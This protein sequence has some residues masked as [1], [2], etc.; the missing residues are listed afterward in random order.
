MLPHGV[1]AIIEYQ[2][3]S[4]MKILQE[5]RVII[6]KNGG[7]ESQTA[8]MFEK[9]GKIW[10]QEHDQLSENDVLDEAIEA[11][12]TD[13][14][15]EDGR[16]V[17]ETVPSGLSSVSDALQEKLKL[18]V[19]RADIIFDPKEASEVELSSEQS[20]DIDRVLEKL[21]DEPCL[22]SIYLNAR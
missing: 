22:Q 7:R 9:K 5:A 18:I 6:N 17:V 20:M 1:A 21:E 15:T 12:A 11:G 8:F 16:I 4:K 10:F 19:E 13:V 14:S 2:T 3:D